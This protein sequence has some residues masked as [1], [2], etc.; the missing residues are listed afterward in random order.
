MASRSELSKR[1]MLSAHEWAKDEGRSFEATCIKLPEGVEF[2][3]LE[4]GLHTV[5]FMPYIVG[6]H[7]PKADKSYPYYMRKY[8]SHRIAGIDGK[9]RPY[10]CRSDCFGLPCPA[11][12]LLNSR[13]T[14]KELAAAI[15]I[16]YRMLWLVNDDPGNTK[17]KWKVLDTFQFNRGMGFGELM[18]DAI[19]LLSEDVE[20]FALEGGCTARLTVKEQ[21]MPGTKFNAVTRIDFLKRKYD[22][23]E[24]LLDQAPC[25]DDMIVDYGEEA[26]EALLQGK[27]PTKNRS[28]VAGNGRTEEDEEEPKAAVKI[29]VA[30]EVLFNGEAYTVIKV[31]LDGTSLTLQDEEGETLRGI[32]P[33]Q[34]E[35]LVEEE[36][37]EP[38]SK[39]RAGKPPVS[40]EDDE[41]APLDEDDNEEDEEEP[42]IRRSA[43]KSGRG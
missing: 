6:D 4:A 16:K 3:K 33:A 24:S 43:K 7:N 42:V 29:A 12:K 39:P 30:D 22:Y 5:D 35:K 41:D 8:Q 27:P 11:C 25:L 18:Q 14:P 9:E 15:K 21:S 34:V 23:P 40:E 36:E 10:A 1:K 37:E 17:P 31:S 32:D 13:D 19:N 2:Y 20:P 28:T 26:M 38:P